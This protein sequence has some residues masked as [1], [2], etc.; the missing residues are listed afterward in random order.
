ME[1]SNREYQKLF[2]FSALIATLGYLTLNYWFP[3]LMIRIS[4]FMEKRRIL[5]EVSATTASQQVPISH[6]DK[7][8]TT[9]DDQTTKPTSPVIPYRLQRRKR[10]AAEVSS[11]SS[12]TPAQPTKEDGASHPPSRAPIPFKLRDRSGDIS[13]QCSKGGD[14]VSV[15]GKDS[16]PSSSSSRQAQPQINTP[17]ERAIIQTP[18]AAA[19]GGGGGGGERKAINPSHYAPLPPVVLTEA[20]KTLARTRRLKQQ[21]DDEYAKSVKEDEKRMM[22]LQVSNLSF[23]LSQMLCG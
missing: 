1:W 21:Q 9:K 18:T 14:E 8:L 15:Q 13:N 2:V 6:E 3:N 10:N 16:M 7:R 19:R 11:N 20:E 4:V 12:P 22:E 17:P 5:K 23:K